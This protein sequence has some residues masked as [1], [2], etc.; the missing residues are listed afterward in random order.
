MPLMTVVTIITTDGDFNYQFYLLSAT[1]GVLVSLLLTLFPIALY[2]SDIRSQ[3]NKLLQWVHNRRQTREFSERLSYCFTFD[4]II[5]EDKINQFM[6]QIHHSLIFLEKKSRD[7]IA[8][9][10]ELSRQKESS[11]Q[12][13]TVISESLSQICESAESQKELIDLTD[14]EVKSLVSGASDMIRQ[15]LKQNQSIQQSSAS[16]SEISA[17]VS[18]ITEMTKQATITS[19]VMKEASESGRLTLNQTTDMIKSIQAASLDIQ[20]IL[21]SIQ[22]TA[23]QTNLL[24]MNASIE[25]AHAGDTGRGF[26]I[27]ADE[28]RS[29]SAL[30]NK[31]AKEIETHI[32]MMIE[33]VNRG[34]DAITA[35][36][37]AFSDIVSSI[38]ENFDL[39]NRISES[40][41]T[42]QKTTQSTLELTFDIVKSTNQISLLSEKQNQYTQ[43]IKKIMDEVVILADHIN[44]NI[45]SQQNELNVLSD[46]SQ[47]AFT[48]I[49]GDQETAKGMLNFILSNR[50][51]S[52]AEGQE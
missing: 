20:T 33:K 16:V 45:T 44:K 10:E 13:L 17:A 24:S 36:G 37:N 52:L 39:M 42:Q 28:V 9:K 27:V 35:A 32:E 25:A 4:M 50:N 34:V 5:L 30:S 46:V 38:D 6:N 18:S 40:M 48:L 11:S 1:G 14:N 23:K 19:T 21:Q 51:V 22:K 12:S 43:S 31:N 8:E 15:V 2:C 49:E 47:Q 41:S 7:I 26:A 29:L 3:T